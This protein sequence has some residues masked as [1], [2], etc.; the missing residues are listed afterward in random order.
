MSG[1]WSLEGD[2]SRPEGY[3]SQGKAH[4]PAPAPA[5]V[6][7][8]KDAL[9]G[10]PVLEKTQIFFLAMVHFSMTENLQIGIK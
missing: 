1:P 7:K 5:S 3:L 8:K 2:Q 6:L 4:L 9:G 10:A